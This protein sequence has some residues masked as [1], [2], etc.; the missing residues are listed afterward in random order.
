MAAAFLDALDMHTVSGVCRGGFA[1]DLCLFDFVSPVPTHSIDLMSTTYTVQVAHPLIKPM[2]PGLTDFP[3]VRWRQSSQP[4]VL[5]ALPA[6]GLVLANSLLT[7][8]DQMCPNH[9]GDLSAAWNISCLQP[10]LPSGH[11]T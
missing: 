10:S 5:S 3:E 6:F 2:F 1:R 8:S 4:L 11:L 9:F 7:C